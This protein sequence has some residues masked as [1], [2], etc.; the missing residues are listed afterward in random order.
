M[1]VH[2]LETERTV[3]DPITINDASFFVKLVNSPDWLHFIGD[4]NVS[5]IDDACRY[6]QNDFLRSYTD[7]G[8]GYYL[9]RTT[10]KQVP[11]GICGFLQKP[12]LENPDFGFALLPDYYGQGFA[13]ESCR[14]VLDYGIQAFGFSILDAVT[15][16]DNARSMRL[17][18]KLGF[19]HHG[20]TSGSTGDDELMFYRWTNQCAGTDN[21]G[22]L[23]SAQDN[24]LSTR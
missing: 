2:L 5:N 20:T 7:N 16:P 11:I 22:S 21:A 9:V 15:T 1:F 10:P 17:L 3:I 6:L 18:E 12:T 13:I 4:R 8:F 24:S 14:A 23:A 19:Q